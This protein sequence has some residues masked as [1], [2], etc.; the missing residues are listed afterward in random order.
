MTFGILVNVISIKTVSVLYYGLPE[1][2]KKKKKKPS[3]VHGPHLISVLKY[4]NGYFNSHWSKSTW[5]P[6]ALLGRWA[7]LAESPLIDIKAVNLPK[8]KQVSNIALIFI[9]LSLT[10]ESWIEM[11]TIFYI[12]VIQ[13]LNIL[14]GY[15]T[16]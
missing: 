7:C 15:K 6:L 12:A 3:S 5:Q 1:L 9:S 11:S 14:L 2:K 4:N 16:F 13:Y 10:L 8:G